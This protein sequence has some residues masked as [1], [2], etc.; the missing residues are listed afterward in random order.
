VKAGDASSASI[1]LAAE[2][3]KFSVGHGLRSCSSRISP[4]PAV[5]LRFPWCG[6]YV[7]APCA[8]FLGA[9]YSTVVHSI[10]AANIYSVPGVRVEVLE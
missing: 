2:V 7:C 1:V 3:D 10:D 5:A 8:Y 6:S 9:L 4:P